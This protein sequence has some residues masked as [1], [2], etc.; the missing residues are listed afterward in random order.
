MHR[1]ALVMTV[2]ASL[3]LAGCVTT[4]PGAGG[5]G[6][7]PV[8]TYA[9]TNNDT[10]YSQC[11]E[12]WK[13]VRATHGLP[14]VSV[15]EIADKTGQVNFDDSGHALSQGASEMVM[16]A[17]YKTGKVALMERLDLRIPLAEVKLAEQ[18]R[19]DR[20]VED[21][22]ALPASGFIV[23]GAITELNYNIVTGGIGAYVDGM[24]GGK[25]TVLIN[26][27]LDLRVVDAKTF[28]VRYVTS[29]QK[30]IFGYE[31]QANVFRFFGDTLLE[32]E[33]G[34]IQNEPMQLALRSIVEMSVYKIMTDFLGLPKSDDCALV[35]S[36]HMASYLKQLAPHP[37]KEGKEKT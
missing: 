9:V 16:S 32:L 13:N 21:Y 25:R 10:P 19:L 33:A 1:K 7:K 26:V 29:L 11:L 22:G 8:F 17:F 31:V 30:Q 18:K 34:K 24:G 5:A 28:A 37:D 6:V 27:A 14:R 12:S 35:E 15:G 36:D 23:V 20:A 2:A 3:A 4:P